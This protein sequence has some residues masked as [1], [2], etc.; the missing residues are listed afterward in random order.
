MHKPLITRELWD[1]AQKI[2]GRYENKGMPYKFKNNTTLFP[3]KRLLTCGECGRNITAEKK[4]K[5]SGK[6]YTYYRCTKFETNCAQKAVNEKD[7]EKQIQ[8]GLNGL[9]IPQET[10]DCIA[11]GLKQSF[12]LKR[13]TEDVIKQNL[14]DKKKKLEERM[15]IL[16][17]DR[18][19]KVITPEFYQEKFT[20]YTVGIKNLCK[21][22]DR[23]INADIDYYILGTQI[24]ELS[25]NAGFL[26]ENALSNE[27][28]ELMNF[29]LS[30]SKLMDKKMLISY[31]KP[32]DKIYQRVSC[33]DMLGDR[34]SNPDTQDQNLMSCH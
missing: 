17:E 6:E 7:L 12:N 26:Y 21:K 29:L 11:E 28:Q 27:K 32:F 22:I 24:L 15:K 31:K 23:Y 10:Q 19:D 16:Y 14:E 13:N 1:R 4:V 2:L 3:F 18:L 34:D 8:T 30:N 33:N 20:E 25:N 9:K 5:K